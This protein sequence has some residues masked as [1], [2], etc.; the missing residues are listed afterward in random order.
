MPISGHGLYPRAGIAAL[1]EQK[2]LMF[3][4]AMSFWVKLPL[5]DS[6]ES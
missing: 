2:K 1:T 4:V 6:A 3:Q 5:N